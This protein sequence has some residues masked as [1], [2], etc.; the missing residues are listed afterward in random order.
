MNL[1]RPR[2]FELTNYLT[3]HI[4]KLC[5]V[6]SYRN[7]LTWNELRSTYVNSY[8]NNFNLSIINKFSTT[9]ILSKQK[10]RVKDKSKVHI[11]LNALE[12]VIKLE[13]MM[14]KF[15]GTIEN[16]KDN[17]IKYAALRTNTSAIENLPITFEG[18]EYKLIELVEINKRP[19]MIVL[20]VAMFPEIIPSI[21]ETL[22]YYMNLNP[23]VTGTS[24]I[25]II[26]KV[27]KEHREDLA[28]NA[29][30]YF[31]KCKIAISDIR[32]EY[33]KKLKKYEGIP[34]DLVYNGE[35]YISAIQ[36]EYVNEANKLLKEKQKELLGES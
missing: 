30:Q 17:L 12:K 35:N 31:V 8:Y 9:S 27:T 6:E 11:D 34:E 14:S 28:K 2:V 18:S 19:N 32:N 22:K 10:S 24:I 7:I 5:T 36:Q 16:F 3:K 21:L 26:P 33:V 15:N 29:K 25:V 1:L 4:R 23:Q 13:R 20:N